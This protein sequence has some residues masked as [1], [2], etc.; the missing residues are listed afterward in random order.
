MGLKSGWRERPL[1]L[2]PKIVHIDAIRADC[3]VVGLKLVKALPY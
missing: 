3:I 1:K 2:A